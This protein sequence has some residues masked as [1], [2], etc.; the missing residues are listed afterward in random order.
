MEQKVAKKKTC[1]SA[2]P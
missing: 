1:Y 2:W